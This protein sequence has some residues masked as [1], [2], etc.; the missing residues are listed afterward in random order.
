MCSLSKLKILTITSLFYIRD[1]S[2]QEERLFCV[3]NL[4]YLAAFCALQIQ[5]F[6]DRL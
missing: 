5:Q 6:H 1:E 2:K 4:P 3:P